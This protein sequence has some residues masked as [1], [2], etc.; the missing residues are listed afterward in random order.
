MLYQNDLLARM[1]SGLHEALPQ[2]GLPT[3]SGLRLLTISENATFL[4]EAP[5]GG[6]RL[7]LRVH[8]P[9]YHSVAEIESELAWIQALRACGAV[10]TP[11]PIATLDGRLLHSFHDGDTVH[12]VAAFDWMPGREPDANDDLIPWY[13]ILGQVTAHLHRHSREWARPPGFMRKLW[14]FDTL[15]GAQAH[16]GDWRDALGLDAGGREVLERTQRLLQA[17]VH[18][19][20]RPERFGLIH[21]DMRA[22]NLLVDGEQLCVI[23]FDYCGL[24]WFVYDFAACVSFM[25]QDPRLPQFLA[26]WLEGYRSVAP[27]AA[28]DEAA[29]P[30]FIMLRR[31]Q[32]TAWVAH[33]AETP[34]SQTM[35][36]AYTHGTVALAERYLAA[37]VDT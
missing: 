18:A 9:D 34:T 30:M 24:S 26:A 6:R 2:W 4:A 8:R 36:E 31:M 21:C 5:E 33:H 17:Q 19:Y 14:N 7:I 22:A 28:E 10:L 20:D 16:W 13:R 3:Q 12:R 35:G 32:L 11:A 27:L 23:D 25:E 15:I 1:Q 37:H 29:I